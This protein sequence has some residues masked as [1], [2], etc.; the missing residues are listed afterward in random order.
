MSF[1]QDKDDDTFNI[2]NSYFIGPKAANLPDFRANINTILDELLE[3]RLNYYPEDNERKFITKKVRRSEKFIK[4]RDNFSDVVRKVSQLLGEHSVPFWSPRYEGHMCTD[5]TMPGLLGYFMTMLYN[6]NNVALEASPLTTVAELKAGQQLCNLFGYNTNEGEKP[7]AW[8]HITCDG[9]VANLESIWV[10]RNLKFYPLTLRKAIKEGK[11]N[12]I[13]DSFKVSFWDKKDQKFKEELLRDMDTWTLLNLHPETV[14]DLPEKLNKDYGISNHFLEGALKK[15]HIQTIGRGPLEDAHMQKNP[16]QYF[17]AKTRHYSW[18][19]GLAIAGIGSGNITEIKVDNDAHIDLEELEHKLEDCAKNQVAVYAVVAIIGSTEEGAVDRLS[20][21]VEIRDR[22]Q[23]EHGLSFLIHADAAWGGYFATMLNRTPGDKPTKSHGSQGPIPALCLRQDTEED[24]LALQH[25]DSISVD[26]HKAG[27]I[28][29]P[30]GSLVYRDGRMRHLV[31]WSSPYLSQGSAEN[32]GVYGVE[33]S[34]PGAAAMSTWLSNQTIGLNPGGYGTLLGEAAFTSARL[35][36][37]YAVATSTKEGVRKNFIC[38]PFNK[39]SSENHPKD[40]LTSP[41]VEDE[42]QWIR[43]NILRKENKDLIKD[44]KAMTKLRTLGSDLN[45]NCFTL[46][47]YD[48]HGKI[49]EDIEEANYLMKRVV[50]RLSITNANTDP[51]NIPVYLTSTRFENE[52]YGDCAKNYMKRMGLKESDED[53]FVIRN[54]VMSPFPTQDYFIGHL[55]DALEDIIEQEVRVTRER[56]HR[57]NHVARFLMQGTDNVFLVLQTSFHCANLRQ[58]LIVSGELDEDLKKDY[59]DFKNKNAEKSLILEST[60]PIDLHDKIDKLPDQPFEFGAKIWEKEDLTKKVDENKPGPIAK[61]TIK[62]TGIVKSRPLNSEHREKKYPEGFTPFYLYGTPEQQHIS[63][64]LLRAPNIALS[65]GGVTLTRQVDGK[66]VAL[67]DDILSQVH[68][69]LI[70]TLQNIPEAAMQPF[71]E[72]NKELPSQFFFR[73][74]HK[75]PV[76]IWKDPKPNSAKGPGLLEDLEEL[77]EAT[78]VLNKDVDIDAEWPNNDSYKSNKPDCDHWQKELEKISSV[79]NSQ[80]K[81]IN[82]TE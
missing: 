43:D 48:E 25:A 54:V 68:N 11:L 10:A 60:D 29:Y 34:K 21:I 15:F 20:K 38:V 45:I 39:L 26:P 32:I 41:A 72:K 76:K 81:D 55:M 22:M 67:G 56:N 80:Y 73:K 13:G 35:S 2:V 33:G 58:Q 70:L 61:G 4:I 47:W 63:H 5:L 52:L 50:D 8:G 24:L 14:L 17:L 42:R 16:A 74:D 64:M 69:G 19:K 31:T 28:P 57:G 37:R 75:F 82:N 1:G 9:T 46:N 53:L 66:D 3:T 49:N 7:L 77:C 30:A 27:Y 6:P 65:A 36:V 62:V 23:R 51:S 79:L 59:V 78:M 71:P 18:P 44:D 40:F 12:F